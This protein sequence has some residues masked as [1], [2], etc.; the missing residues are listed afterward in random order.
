MVMKNRWRA[1]G[2]ALL[3]FSIAVST[4]AAQ[5]TKVY[6]FDRLDV[7]MT[8]QTNGDIDVVETQ[9]YS[10]VSGSF[11]G[12]GFRDIDKGRFDDI[13]NV[14]VSENGKQYTNSSAENPNTYYT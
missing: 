7:D 5:S 14:S 8:V 10:Y 6:R 3:L 12:Y 9:T 13:T 4:A 11:S 1:L 2:L